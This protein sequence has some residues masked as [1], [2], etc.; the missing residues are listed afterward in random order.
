MLQLPPIPS[1][2]SIHPLIVH[3]PIVLLLLSPVFIII[4]MILT[5]PKGRPYMTAAL[6]ILFLGT[7]SLFLAAE[8]G[9]AGALLAERLC[10]SLIPEEQ[11]LIPE[12]DPDKARELLNLWISE[13][14]S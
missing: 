10:P 7:V 13:R 9:E 2:D 11:P 5:P 6:I 8:S 12:G 14:T 4:S 1:W 3:F